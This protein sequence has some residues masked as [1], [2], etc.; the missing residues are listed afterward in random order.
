MSE[1]TRQP[2]RISNDKS[3]SVY[4]WTVVIDVLQIQVGVLQ[5]ARLWRE[6]ARVIT[7]F[8]LC[9]PTVFLVIETREFFRKWRARRDSNAGPPA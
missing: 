6:L 1:P 4:R 3:P 9:S 2:V 8:D 7:L 5:I